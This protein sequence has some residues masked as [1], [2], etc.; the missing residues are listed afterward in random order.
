M[1]SQSSNPLFDL[2]LVNSWRLYN[3]DCVANDF[4]EK[5]DASLDFRMD[6]ADTLYCTQIILAGINSN[7]LSPPLMPKGGP[8]TPVPESR[9]GR[10]SD[11]TAEPELTSKILF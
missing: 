1:D 4:R 6:I 11:P 7:L 2:A 9:T 5:K 8:T 3:N 10:G